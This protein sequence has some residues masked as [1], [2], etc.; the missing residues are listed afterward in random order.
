METGKEGVSLSV[1]FGGTASS[2][3]ED[4]TQIELFGKWCGKPKVLFDGVGHT[5]GLMGVVFAS[6]LAGQAAL[7][8]RTVKDLLQQHPR[9]TVNAVGLSRGGCG[10]LLLAQQLQ[11]AFG[12]SV[13]VNLLLFD[14]VPGNNITTTKLDVL[15]LTLAAQCEDLRACSCVR[16]VLALYPRVPLR[17]I[18]LHAPVMPLFHES[19]AVEW[20]VLLGCHQGAIWSFR[21]EGL[22][23]RLSFVMMRRFLLDCGTALPGACPGWLGPD[24]C[25]EEAVLRDLDELT[26]AGLPPTERHTHSQGGAAVIRGRERAQF[27]NRWHRRMRGGPDTEDT[28][29]VLCFIERDAAVSSVSSSH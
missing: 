11:A 10:C 3:K 15:R 20:D 17:A 12:D 5:N 1:F 23:R 29:T 13:A 27:V 21:V 14:P 26:A 9:V 6:G 28:D 8:V 24:G 18:D 22:D 4:T 25:G 16:R 19:T 7:V 2:F